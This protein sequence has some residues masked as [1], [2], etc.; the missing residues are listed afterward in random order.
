VR[1]LSGD[2]GILSQFEAS[3]EGP[4]GRLKLVPRKPD[5]EVERA[6]VEADAEGRIVGIEIW[7]VQGNK[8]RFTFGRM[9]ENVVLDDR[10][11]RFEV[12][13]GVAVI[14]E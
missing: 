7:D 5:P 12:P 2:G 4:G 8:S 10:Q 14:G 13:K 11:F 6:Y 3:V 1:L 9:K